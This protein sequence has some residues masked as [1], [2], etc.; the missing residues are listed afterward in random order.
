MKKSMKF[1]EWKELVAKNR[2]ALNSK[3]NI[4]NT[5][6]ESLTYAGSKNS[7]RYNPVIFDNNTAYVDMLLNEARLDKG[8]ENHRFG[9]VLDWG[10]G[11]PTDSISNI[12]LTIDGHIYNL[13]WAEDD[14]EKTRGIHHRPY[15][16][17]DDEYYI[18]IEDDECGKIA[19]ISYQILEDAEDTMPIIPVQKHDLIK[20]I[21][22]PES[23][24]YFY[25]NSE[26]SN[27]IS[28]VF[29]TNTCT[30]FF[31]DLDE[32]TIHKNNLLFLNGTDNITFCVG[33][34]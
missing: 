15:D 1:E 24:R 14:D 9:L 25:W 4:F 20:N 29:A 21:H 7:P 16:D 19:R 13:E 22:I 32:Y 27:D 30:I 10:A 18:N 3:S 34:H 8:D 6:P 33:D 11:G 31:N 28:V 2:Q 5:E 26:F 12:K 17:E 23:V